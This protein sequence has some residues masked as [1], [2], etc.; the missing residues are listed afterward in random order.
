[1]EAAKEFGGK[2]FNA[3]SINDVKIFWQ[4]SLNNAVRNHAFLRP[5]DAPELLNVPWEF[6]YQASVDRFI[7]LW[8]ETP[9][10]RYLDLSGHLAPL[11]IRSPLRVLVMIASPRDSQRW[12]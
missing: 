6:L 3:L 1:M 10:V 12:T 4:S 5:S 7:D 11:R 8:V 9:V 2:L